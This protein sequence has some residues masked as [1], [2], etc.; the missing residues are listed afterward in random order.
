MSPFSDLHDTVATVPPGKW[1][2]AVSGGA[3]SVA[4][5]H[6]VFHQRPDV[7]PH[8]VHLDHETREGGS[9]AD[10]DFARV[11]CE[12][13]SLPFT[14]AR[15]TD[16]EALPASGFELPGNLSSRFRTLRH[17][18]F[19]DTTARH[20]LS[21]VLLAHH[22]DDQSETIFQR[23]LRG[24][25]APNVRGMHADSIVRGV[26]LFRPLLNVRRERLRDYLR[27]HDQPWR[28]DASNAS[29]DYQRNR[30]RKLLA[31]RP[32]LVEPLLRLH[33]ANASLK[34]WVCDVAPKLPESF[35]VGGLQD[36]SD[37]LAHDSARAWLTA[38]G[39][40]A[41]ELTPDVVTRLVEM[42]RDA[43]T[44]SRQDF[45]DGVAVRRKGGRIFRDPAR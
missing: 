41:D 40:G 13:W 25:H 42:A 21:G 2:V 43:A 45:P 10:A 7:A 20:T 9:A 27:H 18:L 24:A 34:Q 1:G 31:S 19:A 35:A 3:D 11:L 29:D 17:R 14:P 26:R 36:L 38:R 44:P 30:V 4:L 6:L 16:V 12:R 8:V 23:L 5:L 39:V 28:E 15:R 33:D 37:L 32:G 22:A